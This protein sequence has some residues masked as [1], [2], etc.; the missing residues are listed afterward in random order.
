M[1]TVAPIVAT[2]VQYVDRTVRIFVSSDRS[3]PP[4]PTGRRRRFT[5]P[6]LRDPRWLTGGLA[7]RMGHKV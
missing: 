7:A 4:N 1:N 6:A 5:G 3:A 2:R